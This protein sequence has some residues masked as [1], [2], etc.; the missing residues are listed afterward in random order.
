MTFTF[1][2]D[3]QFI[4]VKFKLLERMIVTHA[5]EELFGANR[6]KL[7]LNYAQFP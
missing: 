5:L 7:T 1:A 4:V 3:S 2:F 6:T